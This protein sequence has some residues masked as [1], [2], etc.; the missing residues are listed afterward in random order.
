MKKRYFLVI[1]VLIIFVF[2]CRKKDMDLPS[3]LPELNGTYS[4]DSYTSWDDGLYEI[5]RYDSW[6]FDDTRK[7]WNFTLNWSYTENGWT[8]ATKDSKSSDIEWKVENNIFYEKL[9]DNEFDSWRSHSFEYIDMNSF[10]L[11]NK[12]YHRE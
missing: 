6:S 8:N 1:I 4:Y 10:K 3:T 12:L 9:W 11:D 5:S 7:A 2:G